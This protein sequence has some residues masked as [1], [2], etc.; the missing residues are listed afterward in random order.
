MFGFKKQL[1]QNRE[2]RMELIKHR[3]EMQ[4]IFVGVLIQLTQ[5]RVLE[6]PKS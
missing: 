2:H 6:E 5:Y 3:I 4:R 1:K